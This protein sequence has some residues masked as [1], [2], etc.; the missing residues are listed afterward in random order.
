M[1]IVC[2]LMMVG[3]NFLLILFRWCFSFVPY[4][5]SPIIAGCM[6]S[7]V[8]KKWQDK[9]MQKIMGTGGVEFIEE[10]NKNEGD[11]DRLPILIGKTLATSWTFGSGMLCGKEGPGLLIGSNLGYIISKKVKN[12]QLD[13][14][15]FYFIGASAC[16]S[17]ILRTP[18]S[19]ALFCAELPYSNHIRYRSL[20]PSIIS[21]S[22]A[23]LIFCSF[24]GFGP[25]FRAELVNA[26]FESYLGLVPLLIIFGIFMGV[27]I[28]LVKYVMRAS[29]RRIKSFSSSR[30]FYWT[31]PLIGAAIYGLFLL[32][33]IPLIQDNHERLF[34]GPDVAFLS[35]L[36]TSIDTMTVI[37]LFL[38]I[39]LFLLAMALSI[40]FYNSSGIIL[41]LMLFGSLVGSLFGKLFY[42]TS[43][44]LFAV[45]GASVAIGAALNNPIT[46]IIIIVEMTWE[47]FLFL[48]AGIVTII[49]Y[50]FSGP[51]SIISGQVEI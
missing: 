16:T 13:A 6:T 27:F 36:I 41:P 3:F 50:I 31:L 44:E 18:I 51:N 35:Y 25:L 22:V 2:G 21:S 43:P 7:L 8:V 42:P 34:I 33:L 26:S 29:M 12:H 17:A 40:G 47:P 48:P 11:Y 14:L 28:L 15:D 46:A 4:F 9:K 39:F 32:I 38:Y 10:V 30:S 37:H 20:L 1:S 49:A 45:L 19:G 23:Y 24:F 5:L